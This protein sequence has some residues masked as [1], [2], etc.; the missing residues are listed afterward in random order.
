MRLVMGHAHIDESSD[1]AAPG[2][3]DSE[4]SEDCRHRAARDDG[5][6]SGYGEHNQSGNNSH[7]SPDRCTECRSRRGRGLLNPGLAEISIMTPS[8]ITSYSQREF[9]ASL[10]K[11]NAKSVFWKHLPRFMS[12][13]PAQMG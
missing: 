10:S 13:Y 4:A 2:S 3:A 12:S 7:A 9:A 8:L 5:A 6:D 1:Q 11:Q